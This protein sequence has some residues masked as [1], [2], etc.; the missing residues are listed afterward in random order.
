VLTGDALIVGTQ[1][2]RCWASGWLTRE[3][4]RRAPKGH[5]KYWSTQS[6]HRGTSSTTR[7]LVHSQL[8]VLSDGTLS[9]H[10]DAANDR[11][12]YSEHCHEVLRYPRGVLWTPACITL[13]SRMGL[14]EHW[15]GDP[16]RVLCVLTS[17]TKCTHIGT[18][19]THTGYCACLLELAGRS[20]ME[21]SCEL[22]VRR[23]VWHLEDC[24][25]VF[26]RLVCTASDPAWR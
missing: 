14:S 9:T 12:R 24:C 19:G 15:H 23:E 8:L 1:S 20:H 2:A 13:S 3:R 26:V 10:M 6:T 7:V 17:G 5:A 22:A 21:Q 25:V 11:I 18:L 16:N 4:W